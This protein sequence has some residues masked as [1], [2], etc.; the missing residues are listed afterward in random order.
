MGYVFDANAFSELSHSYY[1]GRFPTLWGQSDEL[2]GNG[3]IT[4]T[5][6]VAREIEGDRGFALREWA[7]GHLQLFPTPN[8]TEAGFVVEIFAIP[9]FLQIIK[10]I[11]LPK[12][13]LNA[14][15][16]VIARAHA[17]SG[18]VVT[19]EDEPPRGARIPNI[20][21]HFS[22]PCVSPEGFMEQEDWTF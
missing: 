2:V 1:R 14:D 22:I 20:C 8:A 6:E 12:G 11:K 4:S 9:H 15:L 3:R 5:R 19:L 10:R 21:R 7:A 17:T 16:F 13:D 18:T